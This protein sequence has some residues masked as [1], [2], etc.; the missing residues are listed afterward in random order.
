MV[1][2]AVIAILVALTASATMRV[3]GVQ[4]SKTTETNLMKLHILL[5]Q[6]WKAVIAKA[7]RDQIPDKTY[8]IAGKLLNIPNWERRARALH[9]KLTLMQEFP[10]N[11]PEVQMAIPGY[12]VPQSYQTVIGMGLPLQHM[13]SALLYLALRRARSGV[14]MNGDA[15]LNTVETIATANTDVRLIVDAWGTPLI[16]SRWPWG[17]PDLNPPNGD[18]QP[19]PLRDPQDPNGLLSDQ[20][21][22]SPKGLQFSDNA[23]P[24][25]FERSFKLVP[26]IM[27]CGPDK[28]HGLDNTG[29]DGPRKFFKALKV[30]NQSEANDNIYTYRLRMGGSGN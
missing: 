19:L 8:E 16:F 10:V 29:I 24:V 5:D 28:L 13:S 9:I 2:I 26:V 27:S 7:N 25:A 12:P 3:I 15:I 30:L 11:V 4:E 14:D 22:T 20:W 18:L 6:H 17:D 21:A 1:V 23:H